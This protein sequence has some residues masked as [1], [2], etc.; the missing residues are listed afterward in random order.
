MSKMNIALI[1]G[2]LHPKYGGPPSVIKAHIEGLTSFANTK[3]FG[4]CDESDQ[5]E[6]NGIYPNSELFPAVFPKRWFRGKGLRKAL[7]E[8]GGQFDVLHAHMFWDHAVWATWKS[9]KRNHKPFIV[10]PHGSILNVW[11]W[12]PLHKI[13]Y[14][15]LLLKKI[16]EDCSFIHALNKREE[17]GCREF[18]VKCPIRIIPNGLL[19]SEYLKKR[20]P[21]AALEK[22]PILKGKRVL[23]FM[24]RLS[25]LKG[26]DILPQAWAE[27][28]K[29]TQNKDWVLAIA[30]PD[31]RG[32]GKEVERQVKDLGLSDRVVLTGP[33]F[34]ELKDSLHSAAEVFVLPSYTEGFSV[35]LLEALAA[36]LPCLYTTECHFEELAEVGGGWC[37]EPKFDSL[38]QALREVVV[39]SQ[40]THKS[41]GNKAN[42]LGLEK[43]TLENV[44]LQLV[45]MYK[46]AIRNN[47]NA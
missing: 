8:Q 27:C 43:Y 32:F 2:I 5:K 37:I 33:V 14:K 25:R 38:V 34:G 46:D 28:L 21:H 9:G 26:L 6:L 47:S 10:T 35:A 3:V 41:I 36:G 17:Q 40:E 1:S 24:A 7:T 23:L 12:K 22:W 29:K 11:R 4:V 39:Q 31:Y 15:K 19:K 16:L 13:S 30:G 20:E 18:D 44:A 42:K 45:E